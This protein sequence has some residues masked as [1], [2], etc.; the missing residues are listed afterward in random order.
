MR[1]RRCRR[2]VEALRASSTTCTASQGDG[3]AAAQPTFDTAMKEVINGTMPQLSKQALSC[4]GNTYGGGYYRPST[5]TTAVIVYYL[6][7]DQLCSG[8]GGIQSF[9]KLPQEDITR[10]I[11]TL[12]PL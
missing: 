7:G 12:P 6:R 4:G 10:C 11:A 2:L 5:G 1:R 9:S 3:G 8:I